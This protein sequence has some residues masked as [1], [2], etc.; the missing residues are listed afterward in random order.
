[1]LAELSSGSS[2]SSS[3]VIDWYS[4]LNT[5][6][7]IGDWTAN[8][9]IISTISCDAWISAGNSAI[10]D[11]I[12]T[13]TDKVQQLTTDEYMATEP[14]LFSCFV[15]ADYSNSAVTT[16][17]V[18]QGN[19]TYSSIMNPVIRTINSWSSIVKCRNTTS[20]SYTSCTFGSCSNGTCG[21]GANGYGS[22]NHGRRSNGRCTNSSKKHGYKSYGV[23]Q[24]NGCS[25]GSKSHG[26]KTHGD[27]TCGT[28]THQ[29]EKN[30][31]CACTVYTQE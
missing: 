12:Y 15:A 4:T 27:C 8:G 17:A 22:K 28:N 25:D 9:T 29:S 5:I 6:I 31:R 26:D 20:Y 23:Y 24:G 10:A 11:N 21:N 19:V 7:D 3:D 1:M 30:I 2:M 14:T 16:Y 13:L 18:K